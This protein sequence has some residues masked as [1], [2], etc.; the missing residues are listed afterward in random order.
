MIAIVMGVAGSGKTTVGR[1]LAEELG[2]EFCEGDDLH[3][4]ENVAKMARGEPLT[5]EDRRPWLARVR[6]RMDEALRT[7]RDLVVTCSALKAAYRRILRD[8]GDPRVRFVYLRS[9]PALVAER[10]ARREGHFMKASMV[11][12]QFGA[13]EEPSASEALILDAGAPV[14]ALVA[15]MRAALQAP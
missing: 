11:D 7:E 5:D 14:E 1:R 2:W 15:S 3:P 8:D 4:P 10:V 6:A 9:S 13:L 12:S